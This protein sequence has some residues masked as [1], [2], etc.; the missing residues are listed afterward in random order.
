VDKPLQIRVIVEDI[1]DNPPVCQ[2][3]LTVIEVQENEGGGKK[4]A[5]THLYRLFWPCC[6]RLHANKARN[7][8][9]KL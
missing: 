8:D 2:Q 5:S 4:A 1:N 9:P 3:A 7:S 6:F